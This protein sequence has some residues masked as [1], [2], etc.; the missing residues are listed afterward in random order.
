ME[1]C[2]KWKIGSLYHYTIIILKRA[3]LLW[4][5]GITADSMIKVKEAAAD[6]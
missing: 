2:E 6:G 3:I 4:P 5:S 1:T